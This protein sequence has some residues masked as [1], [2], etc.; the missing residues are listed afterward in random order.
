MYV[1]GVFAILVLRAQELRDGV[2]GMTPLRGLDCAKDLIQLRPAESLR[3]IL[4]G[5]RRII[6]PASSKL[7]EHPPDHDVTCQFL[8]SCL[9]CEEG[10]TSRS[11]QG[12]RRPSMPDPSARIPC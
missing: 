2:D 8:S 7:K 3:S 6:R 4:S 9:E 1:F 11:L 5:A 10:A 12:R